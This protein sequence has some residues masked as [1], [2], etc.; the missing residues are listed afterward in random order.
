MGNFWSKKRVLV[1]GHTGFKGAWL[2]LWLQSLGAKVT[3]YALAA[4]T[5]PSLFELANVA[6]GMNS[7]E[8]DVRDLNS[9]DQAFK[10]SQPEIVFHL[11]AQALV[12]E[13]YKD[14]VN[15]YSTN[16][17]GT[18][19]VL[20]LVRRIGGV[21][22][23]V[24]V[25]SD[26]CYENR[27]WERGYRE[28]DA[29]GGSDPYAS[30]KACAELVTAAYR[31]SFFNYDRDVAVASVRAGNVIGG[32]DWASDRLIPDVVRAV[33]G[34]RV[35]HIRNPSA[36][37]PWQHVLEP[38]R[39]YLILAARLYE[40]G[41]AFAESWNFGPNDHDAKPVSWVV[42]QMVDLWDENIKIQND[43]GDN[44]PETSYLKLEWSKAAARLGWKPRLDLERAMQWT[45]DW[46]AGYRRDPARARK[47]TL[48][49][50]EQYLST[51]A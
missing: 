46:Y 28:D 22:A 26:K 48:N 47:L 24:N 14:P 19:H 45:V 27:E 32:G 18:V 42:E 39:G 30:S 7:I 29:L 43:H 40:N 23:V 12:R 8:G 1:T 9:L 3:G 35:V 2:S 16:V 37:R 13:S 44:P 25:T 6:T 11:A 20:E 34:D 5:D 4:P 41:S 15:T 50:I 21:R 33:L 31:Q 38:L 51:D 49:Q 36:V 17:I 10:A